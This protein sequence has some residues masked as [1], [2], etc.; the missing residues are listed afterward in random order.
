MTGFE[1]RL[2]LDRF[3]EN[4][5][6]ALPTPRPRPRRRRRLYHIMMVAMFAIV[7][8][9]MIR[10]QDEEGQGAQDHGRSSAEGRRS[11]PVGPG[12]YV[13]PRWAENFLH[14]DV[15]EGKDGAV[16]VIVQKT[17]V[18]NLFPKGHPQGL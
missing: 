13:S 12:H 4:P 8:L 17:A 9:M 15:S 10:P 7:W 1:C 14:V 3:E 2:L 5:R 18:A 16:Q 6:S 11:S